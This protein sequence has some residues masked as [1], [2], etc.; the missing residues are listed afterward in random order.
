[1]ESAAKP[2]VGVTTESR[3]L[4][5]VVVVPLVVGATFAAGCWWAAGISLGLFLGG[6]GMVAIVGPS[7][8]M[9]EERWLRR[10]ITMGA[11]VD[12]VGIVWLAAVFAGPVRMGQWLPCYCVLAVFAATL[13]GFTLLA[14][15]VGLGEV[16]AAG[17]GVVVGVLWLTWT[18]WAAAAI[19]GPRGQRVA[20]GLIRVGPVFA[21]NSAVKEMGVWSERG[22]AYR[23]TNLN[24]TVAYS[25]P[26]TVWPCVGL[27]VI[28][29]TGLIYLGRQKKRGVSVT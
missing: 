19:E 7:M 26:E 10:V 11:L 21:I 12:G 16:A 27:H 2:L 17:V 28:V 3:G 20:G 1:L 14:W 5:K 18:V 22:I 15:K 29:G 8:A 4:A 25:L 13:L 24:Q 9:A 23:M 6:L